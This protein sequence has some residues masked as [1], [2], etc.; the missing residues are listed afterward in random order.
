MFVDYSGV[1]EVALLTVEGGQQE[2]RLGK[3]N[4]FVSA[5]PQLS[6][7][8]VIN[9]MK[10]L[11][12]FLWECNKTCPRDA[13]TL[14]QILLKVGLDEKFVTPFCKVRISLYHL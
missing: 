3:V 6:K 5:N 9:L 7:E 1:L 10:V 8:Q 12:M 11:S 14:D 13:S 2:I 4:H